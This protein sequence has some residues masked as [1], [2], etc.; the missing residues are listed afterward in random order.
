[1][2]EVTSHVPYDPR[3]KN[4][5]QGVHVASTWM[6]R[7]W[8]EDATLARQG[9]SGDHMGSVCIVPGCHVAQHHIRAA[10]I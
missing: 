3:R 9:G 2:R 5:F 6:L 7:G 4:F 10:F 1:M 8:R